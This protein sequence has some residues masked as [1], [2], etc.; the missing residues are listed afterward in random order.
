MELLTALATV[1]WFFGGFI[2]P[3]LM[4]VMA[5]IYF[6]RARAS[7]RAGWEHAN[8]SS[9]PNS[10]ILGGLF[11]GGVS[12]IQSSLGAICLLIAVVFFGAFGY[13]FGLSSD[14]WPS[15]GILLQ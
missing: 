13:T 5:L 8:R 1:M 3:V 12:M 6:R 2:F 7:V 15:I 9:N 4:I 10:G 14:W 11:S